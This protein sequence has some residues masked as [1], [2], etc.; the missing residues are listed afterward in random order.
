M[1]SKIVA[2]I[3][4]SH[5]PSVGPAVDRKRQQDPAWKP[6]F[7]AYVPHRSEPNPTNSTRRVYFAT[8]NRASEGDHL[9]RYYA[10]KRRNYPPDIEREAGREYVYKV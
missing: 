1:P 4:L 6:L 3:G 10:D 7:D 9:E 8:Y 5:V 2:G